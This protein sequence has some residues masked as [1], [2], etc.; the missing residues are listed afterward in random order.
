MDEGQQNPYYW[1]QDSLG[2][3]VWHW[4]SW[5]RSLELLRR[6]HGREDQSSTPITE[7]SPTRS[8]RKRT[9]S[10]DGMQD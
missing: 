2:R 10:D 4:H 5:W 9:S 6:D 7:P 8:K 3:W 1:I